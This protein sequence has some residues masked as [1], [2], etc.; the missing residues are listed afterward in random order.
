[1][2]LTALFDA[3]LD[4]TRYQVWFL[5]HMQQQ[6]ESLLAA[7]SDEFNILSAP[8]CPGKKLSSSRMSE[9][10]AVFEE[11]VHEMRDEGILSAA[12]LKIKTAMDFAGQ[13]A[14]LRLLCDELNNIRGALQGLPRFGQPYPTLNRTGTSYPRSI[15]FG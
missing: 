3:G 7:I 8:L 6:I 11:K 9:A 10:F 2:S 15:G 5:D 14:A 12:P 13:F 1:V 4:L